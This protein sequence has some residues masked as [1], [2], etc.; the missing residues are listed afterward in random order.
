MAQAV[1]C[2]SA[3]SQCRVETQ[4][5]GGGSRLWGG[6]GEGAVTENGGCLFIKHLG[7]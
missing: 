7:N 1:G 5:T 4:G 3:W 2:S 6:S